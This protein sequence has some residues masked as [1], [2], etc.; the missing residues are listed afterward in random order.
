MKTYEELLE[1]FKAKIEEGY[2]TSRMDKRLIEFADESEK[3]VRTLWKYDHPPTPQA[4][5]GA[6]VI[7]MPT[8]RFRPVKPLQR[9]IRIDLSKWD[10]ETHMVVLDSYM[11]RKGSEVAE[12]E[13]WAIV[14]GISDNAGNTVKAKKKGELS[15]PDIKE[16]QSW[17]GQNARNYADTVVMPLEQKTG[18]LKKGKV[19]LPNKIPTGYVP[20]EDRGPYFAGMIDGARVYWMRFIKDFAL[21]Y[22]KCETIM[23]N[24]P[25]NVYYDKPKRPSQLTIEKWCA[26]APILE[27]AV[28]KITL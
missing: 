21:V 3:P 6:T 25:L 2:E 23:R 28:V 22:A 9:G 17:I 8:P 15:V 7:M 5:H 10:I 16:A 11:Y 20:E 4:M 24:T 14:K 12:R 27:Q 26:A 19:W 18:L 1:E 13:Y